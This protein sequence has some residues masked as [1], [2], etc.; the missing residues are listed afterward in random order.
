MYFNSVSFCG[1]LGVLWILEDSWVFIF[2][3]WKMNI[4]VKEERIYLL[5]FYF[6]LMV[7]LR[8]MVFLFLYCF[9]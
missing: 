5:S 9:L 1:F 4:E 2:V 3:G 7:G 6:I 8:E